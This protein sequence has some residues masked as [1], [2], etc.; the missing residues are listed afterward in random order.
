MPDPAQERPK[1]KKTTCNTKHPET[2]LPKLI[3]YFDT[4][5]LFP[6]S[7]LPLRLHLSGAHVQLPPPQQHADRVI[8]TVLQWVPP[9][10]IKERGISAR[11]DE[12]MYNVFLLESAI[13]IFA[14][15]QMVQRGSSL[16]V[17]RIRVSALEQRGY[18]LQVDCTSGDDDGWSQ[19]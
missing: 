17:L 14:P 9:T 8:A 7:R 19:A 1:K 5:S 11:H 16:H 12:M 4:L 18:Q 3:F 10:V 2:P 15:G 6:T 13:I